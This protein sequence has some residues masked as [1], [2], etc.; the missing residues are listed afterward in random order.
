MKAKGKRQSTVLDIH[1]PQAAHSSFLTPHSSLATAFCL[2][3][4][5]GAPSTA[6]IPTRNSRIATTPTQAKNCTPQ[7][8]HTDCP[9]DTSQFA[10]PQSSHADIST[11]TRSADLP[12]FN[13]IFFIIIHCFVV[14]LLCCFVV[15]LSWV[16]YSPP[17]CHSSFLT[18][19][20]SFRQWVRYSPPGCLI[21]HSSLLIPHSSLRARGPGYHSSFLIPH[22]EP[23]GWGGVFLSLFIATAAV[24]P[25]AG[26]YIGWR[27]GACT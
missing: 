8:I 15:M 22:Y 11:P 10:Q 20:S 3:S 9:A 12:K 21:L 17:G 18:P 13:F 16:R 23:V 1:S 24:K 4:G 5:G 25:K 27:L 2:N 7:G 14:M 6:K 26:G 19:H